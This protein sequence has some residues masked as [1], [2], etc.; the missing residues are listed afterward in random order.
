[1]KRGQPIERILGVE[2]FSAE[3]AA[4]ELLGGRSVN[5]LLLHARQGHLKSIMHKGGKYFR[6]EWLE[7]FI[8]WLEKHPPVRS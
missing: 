7:G 3:Y 4:R 2:Y 8:D 1:M 5:N 6:R